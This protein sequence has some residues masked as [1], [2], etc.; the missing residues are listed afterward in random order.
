[1][2]N[3]YSDHKNVFQYSFSIHIIIMMTKIVTL[4]IIIIY[5]QYHNIN[6]N[7]HIIIVINITEVNNLSWNLTMK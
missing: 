3:K 2:S 7:N 4:I 6:D 5:S 1:M